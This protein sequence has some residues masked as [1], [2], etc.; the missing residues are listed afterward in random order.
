MGQPGQVHTWSSCTEY[1]GAAK[2]TRG[3]ETSQYPEEE[4][5][6]EIPSVAAS[7]Q[8]LAQTPHSLQAATPDA[9][10][11][12]AALRQLRHKQSA[13]WPEVSAGGCRAGKRDPLLDKRSSWEAAPQRVKAP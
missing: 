3:S 2:Q 10:N 12:A 4:K 13:S 1:I 8:G 7:E 9:Q 5:S 6:T 11:R